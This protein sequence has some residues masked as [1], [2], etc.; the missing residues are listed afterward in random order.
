MDCSPR[1]LLCPSNSPGK[2]TRVGCHS[3]LQGI[4]QSQGSNPGLLHFRRIFYHMNHQGSPSLLILRL[5]FQ[6]LKSLL[7]E[8]TNS[9]AQALDS[10]FSCF[11]KDILNNLLQNQFLPSLLA[12][13]QQVSLLWNLPSLKKLL[14]PRLPHYFKAKVFQLSILL[15]PL[16]YLTFFSLPHTTC[17]ETAVTEVTDDLCC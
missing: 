8:K 9:S 5:S 3:L 12:H 6:S 2:N 15:S 14:T 13:T 1:R 7:S 4:F 17:M 10:T 16:P 11:V